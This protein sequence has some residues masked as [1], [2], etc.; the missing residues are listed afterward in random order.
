MI[1]LTSEIFFCKRKR[2]T[3]CS[4]CS[5]TGICHIKQQ[6]LNFF[7]TAH[8]PLFFGKSSNSNAYCN[9]QCT[10]FGL[11]NKYDTL[12]YVTLDTF[13]A[14][15]PRP[16]TTEPTHGKIG[17]CI[18]K[19][20]RPVPAFSAPNLRLCLSVELYLKTKTYYSF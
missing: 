16:L 5:F 11:I 20:S 1:I 9:G 7:N 17:D 15:I 14:K 2:K 12:S 6:N 18:C 19:Q 4:F 3:R 13:E 8:T 10:G